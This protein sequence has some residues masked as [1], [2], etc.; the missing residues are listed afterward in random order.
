MVTRFGGIAEVARFFDVPD[1]R[2]LELEVRGSTF[3]QGDFQMVS[4]DRE[5]IVTHPAWPTLRDRSGRRIEDLT[6]SFEA[7]RRGL[8]ADEYL[9]AD[10]VSVVEKCLLARDQ[11]RSGVYH[12]E[13]LTLAAWNW[14]DGGVVFSSVPE[15]WD[16]P[17]SRLLRHR[18]TA[19]G[20][21][22]RARSIDPV[23]AHYF[24]FAAETVDGGSIGLGVWR[25]PSAWERLGRLQAVAS[26]LRVTSGVEKF[27]YH[28]SIRVDPAGLRGFVQELVRIAGAD[29]AKL[30]EVPYWRDVLVD[31]VAILVNSDRDLPTVV[32]GIAW[33]DVV[34]DA[35]SVAAEMTV[36]QGG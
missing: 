4:G 30:E 33:D 5:F 35:R 32:T 15:R 21:D 16:R 23:E 11:I 13:E 34:A 36:A 19:A 8:Q 24:R 20:V 12:Q 22:Y 7:F 10:E 3:I 18:L 17:E 1:Y 2:E 28:L 9:V 25:Q 31:A 26:A 14:D 6:V 27:P 29:P